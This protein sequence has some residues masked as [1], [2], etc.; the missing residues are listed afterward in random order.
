MLGSVT[1]VGF[2]PIT[3]HPTVGDIIPEWPFTD[4]SLWVSRPLGGSELPSSDCF[5]LMGLRPLFMSVRAP[6]V[7]N[8]AQL[9]F[10][11]MDF[12]V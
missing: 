6:A 7:S 5:A 3:P 9:D 2:P 12:V 10:S 1:L 8:I 4:P 11:P